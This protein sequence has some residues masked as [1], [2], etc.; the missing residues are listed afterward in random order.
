[1]ELTQYR[2]AMFRRVDEKLGQMIETTTETAI[3]TKLGK[4][5]HNTAWH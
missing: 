1:M 4:D 5:L 2:A 3:K